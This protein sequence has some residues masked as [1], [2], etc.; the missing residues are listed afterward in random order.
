MLQVLARQVSD[1]YLPEV[2]WKVSNDGPADVT[3]ERTADEE[4]D[5][6]LSL[7]IKI[8]DDMDEDE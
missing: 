6:A 4:E 7:M 5:L 3:P 8:D 2:F 1:N